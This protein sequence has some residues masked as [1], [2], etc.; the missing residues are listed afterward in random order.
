MARTREW[1]GVAR[2]VATCIAGLALLTLAAPASAAVRYAEPNGTGFAGAGGCLETDP[3]S[4]AD[5]IEDPAVGNGDE[6]IVLPGTYENQTDSL[7]IGWDI[8]VHSRA[9]GPRPVIPI[10]NGFGVQVGSPGA[11]IRGLEID[12]TLSGG[13]T[14]LGMPGGGTAERMVLRHDGTSGEAVL[15]GDGAVVRDSVLWSMTNGASGAALGIAGATATATLRN[16]TVVTTGGPAIEATAISGANMT[17]DAVNVIARG[18]PTD[19]QAV[20]VDAS[21]T[22]TITL[23]NSNFD[24]PFESGPGAESVTSPTSNENQMTPPVFVNAA[25]GDFHQAQ[26]SPTIDAGTPTTSLLGALDLDGDPRIVGAAPDIGA[27]EYTPDTDGDG[28]A[29]IYDNCPGTAN[30]GHADADGD[31]L[32]DACDPTPGG[33]P[34]PDGGGGAGD[35]NP[36]DT[37]ISERPKDKTNRRTATFSFSSSEPGSTFNCVLDGRQQFKA[38]ASPFIVKVGKGT[39]SFSVTATDAAGNVDSSPATDDWKVKRRKKR[40]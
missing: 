19:A 5:A 27:D 22:A 18:A 9:S 21:S 17:I 1:P 33:D 4:L 23:S 11:T 40:R 8:V 24:S 31:G 28:V 7:H 32:G 16:I 12:S 30:A 6:V 35:A 15:L 25:T 2:P 13:G 10:A 20:T 39:H 37:E 34:P 3:C 38:C 29:D 26:T 14:T 36:P